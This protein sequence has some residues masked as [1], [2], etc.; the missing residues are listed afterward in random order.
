MTPNVLW[1]PWPF[2]ALQPHVSMLSNVP[3]KKKKKKILRVDTQYKAILT[4]KLSGFWVLQWAGV[5]EKR[6]LAKLH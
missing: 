4:F 1:L 3:R 2:L 5:I 6:M